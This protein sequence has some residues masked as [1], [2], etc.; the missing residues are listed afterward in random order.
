MDVEDEPVRRN[1]E[2]H[3]EGKQTKEV[4]NIQSS[5]IAR[6]LPLTF[7]A[8]S[9]FWAMKEG[10]GGAIVATNFKANM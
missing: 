9:S 10:F 8:M 2:V 6:V 1:W 7:R 4:R 3:M 5:Q